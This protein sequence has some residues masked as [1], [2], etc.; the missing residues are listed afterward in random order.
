[1]V[2]GFEGVVFEDFL[3]NFIPEIFLRVQL[4]GIRW[5][6]VERDI[7]GDYEIVAVMI[8]GTVQKQQDMLSAYFLAK[9][10]RKILK[11]SVS[12]AGMIR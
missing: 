2:H 12:D 5:E 4:R 10:S 7:G 3:P 8:G 6:E 9:I 11:H 1:M